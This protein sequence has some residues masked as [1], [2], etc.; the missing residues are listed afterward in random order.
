MHY[1]IEN[2]HCTSVGLG[3]REM[4]FF[5]CLLTQCYFSPNRYAN[6]KINQSKLT[7]KDKTVI[8]TTYGPVQGVRRTSPYGEQYHSFEGIPFAKPPIGRLRFRG[9]EEP[10]PWKEVLDCSEV[11]TKPVQHNLVLRIYEGAE[12]C[13]L[14]NVY[15]RNLKPD[16]PLPVLVWIY[17]GGFQVGEA[18]RDLYAPDYLMKKE[19]VL[20]AINYRLGSLGFLSF[21]DPETKVSGNAALKDQVLALKWVKKN[22]AFFGGDPNNVTVFGESAGAASTHYMMLTEQTRGLFHK[23]IVMSGSALAQWAVTPRRNWGF[24]MAQLL[25]Y[26][27]ANNDLDVLHFL[28]TQ[29][30]YDVMKAGEKL[31][32]VEERKS[33]IPF[34]FGPVIEPFIM[35]D[36]VITKAPIE[37]MKEAWSNEIPLMIGGVSFEG[38][39]LS[40]GEF[41]LV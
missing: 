38:L 7:V 16:K 35:E 5:I 18:S 40:V 1:K 34:A 17:G 36:S 27:G 24:R 22:C 33:R 26:N 20:I 30:A 4:I 31:L 21:D 28:Q 10:E 37:M 29:K 19:V 9:P 39:L 2:Y 11:K 23:G 3:R 6:Y 15:S 8:E 41:S 12:D 32:T 13:L 25:G 14:L